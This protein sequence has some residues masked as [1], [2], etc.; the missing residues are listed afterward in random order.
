MGYR[1]LLLVAVMALALAS[2]AFAQTSAVSRTEATARGGSSGN[3]GGLGRIFRAAQGGKL[4]D[5][6]SADRLRSLFS[7]RFNIQP[8]LS[9]ITI[10]DTSVRHTPTRIRRRASGFPCFVCIDC[11]VVMLTDYAIDNCCHSRYSHD[12]LARTHVQVPP[13]FQI[14]T[15]RNF[16]LFRVRFEPV[17]PPSAPTF[18]ARFFGEIPRPLT[19]GAQRF[20][21]PFLC[22]LNPAVS[23]K[24]QTADCIADLRTL[25]E[26]GV[27]G[28]ADFG[29]AP[30]NFFTLTIAGKCAADE[31]V[32]VGTDVDVSL[33]GPPTP[34]VPVVNQVNVFISTNK[35]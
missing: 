1:F 33:T 16:D 26:Q 10:T 31:V 8:Q 27:T 6:C 29:P 11:F 28:I 30:N 14:T 21:L 20:N 25:A 9:V 12:V 5:S 35:L 19:P 15:I 22:T 34:G 3:I 17:S 23:R 13:A 4:Y 32:F 2:S 7:S 18:I 24:S